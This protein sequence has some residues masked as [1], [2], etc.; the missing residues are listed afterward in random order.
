MITWHVSNLDYK[1]PF[2]IVYQVQ[3][4]K[5]S[6]IVYDLFQFSSRP[7]YAVYRS[8]RA[9][10]AQCCNL[11]R[12]TLLFGWIKGTG[13]WFGLLQAT[14]RRPPLGPCAILPL[15]HC[16]R[17]LESRKNEAKK[18]RLPSGA[19]GCG[20][21]PRWRRR[22]FP[23]LFRIKIDLF[24]SCAYSCL[25]VFNQFHMADLIHW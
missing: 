9:L 13:S 24:M 4:C 1:D 18:S 6:P 20:F 16:T 14:K 21:E 7:T 2:Y 22:L 11:S 17:A 3:S 8:K 19:Q 5:Y 15:S 25:L 12:E 10:V 23:S